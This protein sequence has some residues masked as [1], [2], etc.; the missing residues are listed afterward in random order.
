VAKQTFSSDDLMANKSFLYALRLYMKEF[1]KP[2]KDGQ[3]LSKKK[4]IRRQMKFIKKYQ[5][6][7]GQWSQVEDMKGLRLALKTLDEAMV[8]LESGFYQE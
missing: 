2:G 3:S 1:S 4:R 6:L 7:I 5:G 8:S